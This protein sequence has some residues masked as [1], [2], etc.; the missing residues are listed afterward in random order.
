MSVFEDVEIGVAEVTEVEEEF[1]FEEM[2]GHLYKT[3]EHKPAFCGLNE[4]ED[5]HSCMHQRYRDEMPEWKGESNCSICGAPFC[6]T[7]IA[8]AMEYLTQENKAA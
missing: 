3:W 1:D 2:T 6:K 4:K 8:L 7:C 5:A